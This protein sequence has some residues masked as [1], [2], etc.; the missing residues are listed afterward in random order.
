MYTSDE[1]IEHTAPPLL[2]ARLDMNRQFRNAAE[3]ITM[4]AA[5]PRPPAPSPSSIAKF[6]MNVQCSMEGALNTIYIAVP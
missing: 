5:P 6:C 4:S 2:S 1:A 3:L